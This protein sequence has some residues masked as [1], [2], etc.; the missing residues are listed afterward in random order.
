MNHI[1]LFAGIGGFEL[2]AAQ[3][4]WNTVAWCEWD[5]FCQHVLKHYFPKANGH[6]DIT[7]TDFIKYANQI[8]ILTGGFPCQPYSSAGKR[9]GKDD[10]RHLW[11][12]MLRAVREIRPRWIVGENVAG[13]VSWNGGLVFEEVCVDLENEGYEVQPVVLPALSVG[14]PHRRDRVWFIAR[15][16]EQ[17]VM[18]DPNQRTAGPSGKS[19]RA[20]KNRSGNDLQPKQRRETPEQHFGYGNVYGVIADTCCHGSKERTP[21][22]IEPDK[23]KSKA[24]P[25]GSVKRYGNTGD[26]ADAKRKRQPRQGRPERCSRTETGFEWKA[27]W[28]DNVSKWPTQSPLCSGDDGL[29]AELVRIT[30]PGRKDRR[31]LTPKQAISRHRKESIKGYGNAIVPQVAIQIYKAIL[32]I[33]QG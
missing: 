22:S 29:P 14:A 30:V 15:R 31:T 9:L 1:G 11:P 18:A 5:P 26:A 16:I 24:R 32:E 3:M 17:S 23:P 20:N 21:H 19:N 13:I 12:Q 8:D 7:K 2:A 27:S 10:V 33:E 4:G 25:H 6:G 28:S